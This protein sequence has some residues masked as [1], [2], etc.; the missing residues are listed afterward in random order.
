MS[1]LPNVVLGH[2][3]WADGSSWSAVIERLQA[4]GCQVT[5][6]QFSLH[7]IADDTDRLRLVLARQDGPTIVAGFVNHFAADIDPVKAKA[8][9]MGADT[10]EVASNH[11]ALVSHPDEALERTTT[12]ARA[13]AGPSR[14]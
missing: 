8:V 2:G 12:A 6:P 7:S 3:T 14:V 11:I 13:V 5:A 9:R 1:A 10:V 4:K